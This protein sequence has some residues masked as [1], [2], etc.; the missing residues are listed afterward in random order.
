MPTSCVRRS[1]FVAIATDIAS[2]PFSDSRTPVCMDRHARALKLNK[3]RKTKATTGA[4]AAMA[5]VNS[6]RDSLTKISK[7]REQ[8]RGLIS[9]LEKFG[10]GD[11]AQ[12]NFQK[13]C[14]SVQGSLTLLLKT[15]DE[16]PPALSALRFS[17]DFSIM[18]EG[19]QIEFLKAFIENPLLIADTLQ[20][21]KFDVWLLKRREEE[22][23]GRSRQRGTSSSQNSYTLS[24]KE[25]DDF[26]GELTSIC[27]VLAATKYSSRFEESTELRGLRTKFDDVLKIMIE[28]REPK[29]CQRRAKLWNSRPMSLIP[30]LLE[31]PASLSA[32]DDRTANTSTSFTD[33]INDL[34]T[35]VE[36]A[37]MKKV[38]QRLKTCDNSD[39]DLECELSPL[40][41]R[42]AIQSALPY[43]S[44]ELR[45]E[46]R[47]K[48]IKNKLE[49]EIIP[50]TI[51]RNGLM[52]F[53][54]FSNWEFIIIDLEVF[55][56]AFL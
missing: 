22:L 47:P 43:R 50:V 30:K 11:D 4:S 40:I 2:G 54:F 29:R 27:N 6:A 32:C 55:L 10:Q 56:K 13:K 49:S 20:F 21:D 24:K 3:K 39:S 52:F 26:I 18:I 28:R 5:Q 8:I 51:L 14:K 46:V 45:S 34:L 33:L 53:G 36:N 25:A 16:Q 1:T 23:S 37:H 41:E 19:L 35:Q 31:R 44:H 9:D 7:A 38:T 17:P 48:S 12:F 15:I 42:F